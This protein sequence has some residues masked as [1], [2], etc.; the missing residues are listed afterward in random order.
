VLLIAAQ[1]IFERGLV[2]IF[3]FLPGI[4]VDDALRLGLADTLASVG[5]DGFHRGEGLLFGSLPGSFFG[6]FFGFVFSH[7]HASLELT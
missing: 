3:A 2:F 4:I 6:S 1:Q 7:G 5:L